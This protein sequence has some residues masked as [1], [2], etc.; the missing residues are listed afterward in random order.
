MCIKSANYFS[1]IFFFFFISIRSCLEELFSKEFYSSK[2]LFK[3]IS[4][5]WYRV[6]S[7]CTWTNKNGTCKNGTGAH[8][9]FYELS[10]EWKHWKCTNTF[11]LVIFFWVAIDPHMIQVS[12]EFHVLLSKALIRL[13]C[14]SRP[15]ARMPTTSERAYVTLRWCFCCVSHATSFTL[16]AWKVVQM[17]ASLFIRITK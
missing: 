12:K 10:K 3:L 9:K 15:N 7:Y 14:R 16:W 2:V 4:V 17:T 11:I 8:C 13:P 1:S 6:H 5:Q